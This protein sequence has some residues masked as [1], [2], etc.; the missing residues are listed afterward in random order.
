[1]AK[2]SDIPPGVSL[3]AVFIL[4][5]AALKPWTCEFPTNDDWSYLIPTLRLAREGVLR[6]TGDSLSTHVLHVVVGAAWLKAL[7]GGVGGLKLLVFAW[8]FAGAYLLEKLLLEA[9]VAPAL[10]WLGVL[11]YVFNPIVLALSATFMTDIPYLTLTIASLYFYMRAVRRKTDGEILWG[12]LAAAGAYLIKQ[13]GVLMPLAVTFTFWRSGRLSWKRMLLAWAPLAAAAAGHQYW[14]H[15]ISGPTWAGTANSV[16]L[17]ALGFLSSPFAAFR[18]GAFHAVGLIFH[19]ALFLLPLLAGVAWERFR[20]SRVRLREIRLR[21]NAALAAF[22]LSALVVITRHGPFPYLENYFYRT[23]IGVATVADAAYKAAGV[24]AWPWFWEIVTGA[25]LAG[26][27]L[28]ITIVRSEVRESSRSPAVVLLAW[29][30]FL[31]FGAS[32]I[33]TKYLDRYTLYGLPALIGIVAIS[34]SKGRFAFRPAWSVLIAASILYLSAAADYMSWNKAKWRLG[35][36]GMALGIA[37]EAIEGGHDWDMYWTYEK[38]MAELQKIKPLREI[39]EWEWLETQPRRAI[40]SFSPPGDEEPREMLAEEAYQ[41]PLSVESPS[42][43]LY[44]KREEK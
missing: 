41:T 43:Y 17:L 1:M 13:L 11:I 32:L 21:P 42:L 24:F 23:G 26:G 25:T 9:R 18:D 35:R 37:P 31:Q 34:L 4:L 22:G 40:I 14:Y 8:Y 3:A 7:G 19:L 36:Q 10:A 5:A 12:S 30:A 6:V 2:G 20:R 29:T 27:L 16:A 39:R 44:R 33:T 15:M 28:L 38:K